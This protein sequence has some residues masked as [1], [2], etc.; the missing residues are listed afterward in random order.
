MP[1]LEQAGSI[2]SELRQQN[3]GLSGELRALVESIEL[4]RCTP[5]T[6]LLV[7]ARLGAYDVQVF[8]KKRGSADANTARLWRSSSKKVK[9]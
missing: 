4:D 5:A 9:K 8:A 1:N 7:A 3:L 2:Y 6:A